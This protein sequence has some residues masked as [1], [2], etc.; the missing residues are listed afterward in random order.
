[1]RA[2]T[3]APLNSRSDEIV[4]EIV[5]LLAG[6]ADIGPDEIGTEFTVRSTIQLLKTLASNKKPLWGTKKSNIAALSALQKNIGNLQ[7]AFN[8]LPVEMKVQLAIK[9]LSEQIPSLSEQQVAI[10]RLEKIAGTLRY[11]EVRCDQLL[12]QPPGEHGNTDFLQ[13]LIA[14]EA[15]R[16][17][18]NHYLKPA[19]GIDGSRYG[20][21]S[22]LLFEA[23]TGEDRD[24]QRACK[25]V[26]AAA[27]KGDFREW[28][29]PTIFKGRLPI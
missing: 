20:K 11:L 3:K 18:K 14:E 9:E 12:S 19:S 2:K 4:A 29:G 23:V 25:S 13:R 6:G 24:L 1:M 21:V 22:N 28:K 17:M 26:L 27:K 15:W 8:E 10:A 7:K 16:L 5:N